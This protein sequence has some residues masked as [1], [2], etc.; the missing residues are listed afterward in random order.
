MGEV[1]A[2]IGRR[3]VEFESRGHGDLNGACERL[4]KRT[5]IGRNT[6]KDWWHWQ[7]KTPAKGVLHITWEKLLNEYEC[8]CAHLAHEFQ[9]E[10]QT[11][12]ELRG[13][14]GQFDHSQVG[15]EMGG[16]KNSSS[17]GQSTD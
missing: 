13:K 10:H 3:L 11:V 4:A 16:K 6:W 5:G 7:C 14:W 17:I 15:A 12:K 8:M 1:A 9:R 2:K